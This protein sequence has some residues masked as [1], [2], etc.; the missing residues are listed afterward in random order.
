MCPKCSLTS[1]RSWYVLSQIFAPLALQQLALRDPYNF[2]IPILT[3][4]G[5][6]GGMLLINLFVLPESPWWLVQRSE[7]DK[8]EAVLAKTHKGVDGYDVKNE[9][10]RLPYS[11]NPTL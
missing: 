3:Q 11:E 5:M 8:A 9:L 6:L 4:W 1:W 10:V 7:F 2:I